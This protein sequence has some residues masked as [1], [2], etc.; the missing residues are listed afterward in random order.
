MSATIVVVGSFN[1]DMITT[2]ERLPQP[3]ETVQGRRFSTGPG[4]KGSNQAVAAARL[5]A[6]VSFVGRIGHD[7]WGDVAL[8]C[9]QEEG[10][11]TDH[12]GRDAELATGV[13]PIWVDDDGENAIVCALG[14]NLALT[15]EH[16]DAAADRIAA[17]DILVLQL[18]VPLDTVAHTL[19]LAQKLD[20]PCILNPAPAQTLMP[21]M[22]ALASWLTPNETE[23]ATLYGETP[24]DLRPLVT[25]GGQ[26]LIQTMGAA[27]ARWATQSGTGQVPAFEVEAL[28]TTGAGDA[29]NGGLAVALAEGRELEDALRLANAVAALS[30][31]RPGTAPAMPG[32]AGVE[33]LLASG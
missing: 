33:A 17:A 28:D 24:E 18:E 29:F 14:A 22:L 5:G 7:P 12:V 25:H 20:V 1:L 13:A 32:R 4:G 19:K 23:L 10:I 16:V 9:W 2:M 3:G 11:N 27:G 30:V 21:E 8:A 6:E 15:T 31:T 26:T